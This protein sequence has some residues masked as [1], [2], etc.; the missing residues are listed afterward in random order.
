MLHRSKDSI[1]MDKLLKRFDD[2]AQKDRANVDFRSFFKDFSTKVQRKIEL[3]NSIDKNDIVKVV[4]WII[5]HVNEFSDINKRILKR[6]NYNT[7]NKILNFFAAKFPDLMREIPRR[8][9]EIGIDMKIN[10]ISE[11]DKKW[12]QGIDDVRQQL[13]KNTI[14]NENLREV[15]NGSSEILESSLSDISFV[16]SDNDFNQDSS[17]DP[18]SDYFYGNYY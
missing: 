6:S 18:D 16:F 17:F 4:I 10:N 1:K 14:T 8:L 5:N 13:N 9:Q 12:K 15:L 2:E 7:V 3:V 11:F